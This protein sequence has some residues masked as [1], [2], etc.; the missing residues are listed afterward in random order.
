MTH[1]KLARPLGGP[2]GFEHKDMSMIELNK[3]PAQ[4]K[5]SG[6]AKQKVSRIAAG[7]RQQAAGS[8]QQE[9]VQTAHSK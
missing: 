6:D 2:S 7:S 1:L 8:K 4:G 3:Q 5:G 9:Q